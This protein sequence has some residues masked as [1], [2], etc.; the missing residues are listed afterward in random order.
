MKQLLHDVLTDPVVVIG[1]C[2]VTVLG[3]ITF[4][5]VFARFVMEVASRWSS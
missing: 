2:V 3:A 5:L 1:A 4:V